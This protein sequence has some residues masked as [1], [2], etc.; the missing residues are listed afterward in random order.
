MLVLTRKP[1]ERIIIGDVVKITIVGIRSDGGVRIGIEAPPDVDVHREEIWN[2][3]QEGKL[4]EKAASLPVGQHLPPLATRIAQRSQEESL[5]AMQPDEWRDLFSQILDC[6]PR[7]SEVLFAVR[8]LLDVRN[9]ML[10]TIAELR[11]K[12]NPAEAKA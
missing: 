7:W 11:A 4:R 3:I 10:R 2:R 9:R 5:A 12:V 1:N 6:D 8:N